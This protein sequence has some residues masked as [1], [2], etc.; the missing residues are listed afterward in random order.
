MKAYSQIIIFIC[1]ICKCT[2]V[3]ITPEL[4]RIILN[5]GYRINFEYDGIL[6]HSFD[7]F[8]VDTKFIWPT[9]DDLKFSPVDFDSECSYLNVGLK[10]HRYPTQ[11]LPKIKNYCMKIVPFVD[12]HKKQIDYYNKTVHAILMKEIPLILPNFPKSRQE[13]RGIITSLVTGFIGLAYKGISSYL[14]N[15]RQKP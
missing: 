9:I 6:S 8:Y 3:N 4:K 12:F 15:K 1:C 5:F 7:R 14:H 13:K 10:R 2:S 11:Y